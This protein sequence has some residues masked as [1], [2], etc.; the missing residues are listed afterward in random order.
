[1]GI[2]NSLIAIVASLAINSTGCRTIDNPYYKNAI[3]TQISF[4]NS[5]SSLEDKV[6]QETL[7]SIEMIETSASYTI[8]D[9]DQEITEVLTIRGTGTVIDE[10]DGFYYILTAQ[11]VVDLPKILESSTNIL[12]KIEGSTAIIN[13]LTSSTSTSTLNLRAVRNEMSISVKGI[14]GAEILCQEYLPSNDYALIRVPSNSSLYPLSNN[15]NAQLGSSSKIKQGDYVYTMGYSLGIGG[16]FLTDG[17]VSNV[18]LPLGTSNNLTL[19]NDKAFM[20]SPSISPGN[21]GGPVFAVAKN[22]LY[23][24]GVVS[25]HY[26]G[27]NDLNFAFKIDEI[28]NSIKRCNLISDSLRL[29]RIPRNYNKTNFQDQ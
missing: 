2:K 15:K 22:K 16:L 11:H 1:M 7:Q 17:I 20:F 5:N 13:T 14:K 19:Y 18:D 26:V 23:L 29:D 25:G 9:K 10:Q 3:K 4:E 6:L 8:K 12:D 24:V 27:G 21:S 28:A